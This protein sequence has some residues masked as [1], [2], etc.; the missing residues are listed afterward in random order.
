MNNLT[1]DQSRIDA[2][3]R[4]ATAKSSESEALLTKFIH[5][6]YQY[7]H[8][9]VAKSISDADLAGMALHHFS[10]LKNH[11][12]QSPRLAVINP[13]SDEHYF[14]SK[15]SVIQMA[16]FDRPFLTDTMLMSL[17]KKGVAV[18]RI[19][20]NIVKVVRDTSGAIVDVIGADESDANISQQY[21]LFHCEIARQDVEKLAEIHDALLA[22]INTLDVIVAD[23]SQMRDKLNSIRQEMAS[24]P[25]PTE[26]N[27]KEEVLDFLE[28]VGDENFIFMGF[29]EYRFDGLGE[30]A[31]L[32]S[33]GGSGLGVLRGL[34]EDSLSQSFHR[35]PRELK[36]MLSLPRAILLSKSRHESPVHRPVYMDFLG[37]HKYDE[38]GKLIGEYRFVGLLTS[39]AYQTRVRNIPLLREKANQILELS[40]FAKNSH[41]YFKLAHIVNTLPRDDL[42]QAGIDELYPMVTAISQLQ[43]KNRLRLFTRID[44]YQRFV[45]CLVYIPRHKFDTELRIKIQNLLTQAFGGESSNFTTEFNELHHARV[46]IHVRTIPGKV[47]PVDTALLEDKLGALMQDW[48]DEYAR[49]LS[50]ELGESEAN[51]IISNYG[52]SVPAAYKERYD[53]NTAVADTKRLLTISSQEPMAWRLYQ[54][55]GESADKLTLKLYGQGEPS[56]LSHVLPILENFGVLVLNADSFKFDNTHGAWIQEYQLKLRDGISVDLNAVRTQFEDSLREIWQG[57]IESDKLN[58]LILTTNLDAYDV[59]LLRALS[60]YIVQARAP[61]SNEYIHATLVNNPQLASLIVSLFH[62]KMAPDVDNRDSAVQSAKDA[63]DAKLANVSSLDEDRIIRWFLDLIQALLRT[64][65]YQV[66]EE[67]NRK[68]RVSFKFAASQIPHLPKPKPM[69]EIYV[70]S[71]RIEGVH[72]RGGKVARGGLRWSDRM[73]DYRTEVLGLVKAQMVKNA[74]IVPVGSKGGFV[75]K[76][77]SKAGNRETWQAEGVACYKTFIRGLLDLTDNLVDGKVIP[78]SNTVRHDE[79]DPYLVVAADKGTATFSDI[80]NGLS[81]EYGFW[82]QDAFASGG[83]A[84]YDHKGMGITAR[85]AWESVKRHF[86]LMGRDIQTRDAF[87]A[88]G[89]GDMSGDVFG[90][91]MLLSN[92][93]RL[94][95]AFNHLHIF[96]DPNPDAKISF[97]ERERLFN[98][99]RSMWTDY[100]AKL[101]SEGGGVFNRTDKSIAITPQMKAAFDITEDSLTPNE[102]L[103]KL[104]KAPVDLI[105]NGG[106][107][108]YIK[109]S[110]EEHSDVGD[111]ANDAIRVNGNEVRAKVVG[112]GGNLGC[113]QKGRI[114]Y[115]QNGGR[116]YTDAI[117]N[118]AGV[119]CSDHEVNIKILLGAV[120]EQDEMTI[121]QRNTLLE[122]M[123]DE[124]AQ[125]VLRQNYLQ[126]QAIELSAREA[127]TRLPEHHQF[128]QFLENAGRLDRAIEYLPSDE[129][130]KER[131]A[132][133]QGL[134]NPEFA[135]LLAYG[136]MWVYDEMLDSDLANDAY[137]LNE[138]KKYFPDALDEPYFDEMVKHRLHREIIS[139]YLTNGL[140]NRLGI[141]TVFDIYRKTDRSIADITRAYAVVRDVFGVQMLWNEIEALDNQISAELQL[142]IEIQIRRSLQSAIISLLNANDDLD[143]ATLVGQHLDATDG[144]DVSY[145]SELEGQGVPIASA[146]LFARLPAQVA[147]MK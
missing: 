32:Y 121:K 59:V 26:Y 8:H 64:S 73:E 123:T 85:G 80:A 24:V 134:T 72:L 41:N 117:D 114:E 69:F 47:K 58:E 44:H 98:M 28:W 49:A 46:H 21:S 95:A 122:S 6:Y 133:A 61:F 112:E 143:V 136:K 77:R 13:V 20:T 14:S 10:L 126:P 62:A 130:I 101:I 108:T 94:L 53:A 70:Y 57:K 88:V 12:G 142:D 17:E 113:T 75:C 124:V 71:P 145:Q 65:H 96:I 31:E 89:I 34:S 128:M 144:V 18:H 56:I 45:S 83:S 81:A 110:D 84:G 54:P 35:L 119:N 93:T 23:W 2:I 99:P 11:N 120:V 52:D 103:N 86:R 146:A 67:G 76:D 39:R 48:S 140:V 60:R 129:A 141:E 25:V 74:V 78:P 100:D 97:T 115:A 43:D 125:L 135:I 36:G 105:W 82:L 33:V 116:I 1:I 40:G 38:Q 90:N 139:T 3:A 37:I 87:T 42:F 7:L 66:D 131:Q 30:D 63:I 5:I 137:F 27:S 127:T 50:E 29:R 55:V 79:D 138:L 92:N 118:S 9:D 132:S 109:S 16:A 4:I 107:G 91:G 104:L 19:Y 111:R 147:A 68:D 22:K 15:K 106:I 102:L 51:R